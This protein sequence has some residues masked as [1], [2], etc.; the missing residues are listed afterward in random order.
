MTLFDESIFS[1]NYLSWPSFKMKSFSYIEGVLT[2]V[3]TYIGKCNYTQSW[4][5]DFWKVSKWILGFYPDLYR[6]KVPSTEDAVF[7]YVLQDLNL[8]TKSACLCLAWSN[9]KGL[10]NI[11]ELRHSQWEDFIW[12]FFAKQSEDEKWKFVTVL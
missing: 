3:C 8:L 2:V 12:P 9:Y 6:A 4:S 7:W 11:F 1:R 5:W 10:D